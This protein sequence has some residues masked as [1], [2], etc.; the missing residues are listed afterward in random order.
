MEARVRAETS[1]EVPEDTNFSKL[2]FGNNGAS[3]ETA[4]GQQIRCRV[5]EEQR[6]NYGESGSAFWTTYEFYM[7]NTK[8]SARTTVELRI[9]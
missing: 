3:L 9:P 1:D 5:V 4:D 2:N 7:P 8:S 6:D